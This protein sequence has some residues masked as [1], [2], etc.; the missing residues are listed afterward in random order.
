MAWPIPTR[1]MSRTRIGVPFWAAT[2]T[3]SMSVVD[4]K[5]PMPRTVI[6]YWPWLTEAP[7]A[8]ALQ[9]FDAVASSNANAGGASGNQ[10]QDAMT[11]RG[12][13]LLRA[14]TDLQN[15]AVAAQKGTP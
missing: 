5:S 7:P 1:A 14:T 2:T 10:G 11:V 8:L 9:G 3:F 6:A 15:R 4:L 13:G 12:I